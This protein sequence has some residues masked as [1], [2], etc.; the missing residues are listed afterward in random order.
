[1][2]APALLIAANGHKWMTFEDYDTPQ[3]RLAIE[4]LMREGFTEAGKQVVWLDEGILPSYVKQGITIAAGFDNWVGNYLLAECDRGDEVILKLSIH[5]SSTDRSA[6]QASRA[7][8]DA[9]WGKVS[10]KE[11]IADDKWL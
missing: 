9:A 10:A 8:A 5:T 11:P 7:A 4:W 1:M 6:A 2:A 3:W